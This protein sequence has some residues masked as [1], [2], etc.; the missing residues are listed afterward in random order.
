MTWPFVLGMSYTSARVSR[1]SWSSFLPCSES[2]LPAL[3]TY[4]STRE[5]YVDFWSADMILLLLSN[6][7]K[8]G[9]PPELELQLAD[10]RVEDHD[11]LL[12]VAIALA[13]LHVDD[14][15]RPDHG[16]ALLHTVLAHFLVKRFCEAS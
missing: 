7:R 5:S 4:L 10:R 12:L 16:K 9:P 2:E 1:T 15:E 8:V 13:L 11:L 3:V 6:C 14:G